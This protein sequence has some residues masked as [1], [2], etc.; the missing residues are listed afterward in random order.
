MNGSKE[1]YKSV[2]VQEEEKKNINNY[3]SSAFTLTG[4]AAEK[5]P[6]FWGVLVLVLVCFWH[7]SHQIVTE[8]EGKR[9]EILSNTRIP[10]S[11][12]D[13]RILN[14]RVAS[15]L[16]IPNHRLRR[17]SVRPFSVSSIECL[18]WCVMRLMGIVGIIIVKGRCRV[19]GGDVALVGRFG[20]IGGGIGR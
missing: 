4:F 17:S 3:A 8:R 19:C 12:K 15:S 18:L 9:S 5:D 11:R 1:I 13:S 7:R 14:P 20:V 16:Y 6:F 2:H 10:L